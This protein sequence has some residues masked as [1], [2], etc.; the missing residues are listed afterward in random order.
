MQLTCIIFL[1]WLEKCFE[2]TENVQKFRFEGDWA[3]LHPKICLVRQSWSK[4]SVPYNCLVG[5]TC[6]SPVGNAAM[7]TCLGKDPNIITN[8]NK[9]L[10]FYLWLLSIAGLDTIDA[11]FEG[12][13]STLDD[14]A[15]KVPVW[16]FEMSL[17]P[18]RTVINMSAS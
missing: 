12:S 11:F 1:S 7:K 2:V 5:W 6:W 15:Q 16:N 10:Y 14:V 4:Y 13:I 18:Y 9:L 17:L 3:E 8:T